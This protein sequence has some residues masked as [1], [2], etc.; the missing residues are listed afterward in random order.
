MAQ[1]GIKTLPEFNP[2]GTYKRDFLVQ[3]DA[4]GLDDKPGKRTV[5]MLLVNMGREAVKIYDSF[6]RVPEVEA[7]EDNN[8]AGEPGEDRHDL[9]TVFRQWGA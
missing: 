7:D 1:K 2:W 4:L 9:D 6:T 5:G 3:L 8:I